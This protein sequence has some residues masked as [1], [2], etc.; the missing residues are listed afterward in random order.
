MQIK[1]HE[2]KEP[3]LHKKFRKFLM[4]EFHVSSQQKNNLNISDKKVK[5]AQ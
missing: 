3:N 2:L 5:V 4:Q 1:R